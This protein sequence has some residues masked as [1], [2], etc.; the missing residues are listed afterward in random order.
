MLPNRLVVRAYAT[1]GFT[2][3]FLVRLVISALLVMARENPLRVSPSAVLYIVVIVGVAGFADL[4][5]RHELALLGNLG[6]SRGYLVAF[7]AVPAIAGEM[8]ILLASVPFR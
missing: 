8:L 7:F 4:K 1:R 2:L 6:V 3:W 5:R